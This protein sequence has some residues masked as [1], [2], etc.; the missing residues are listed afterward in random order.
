MQAKIVMLAL[1]VAS[2]GGNGG[3]DGDGDDDGEE[4]PASLLA[5]DG[6]GGAVASVEAPGALVGGAS[7]MTVTIT[8]PGDRAT[9]TLAVA[10]AGDGFALDATAT[11]CAG[12]MLAARASCVIGVAFEPSELGAHTGTSASAP[13]P[14]HAS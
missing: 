6:S 10:V 7:A 14:R 4:E 12:A 13:R 8:N 1:V 11:T 5:V 9:G 2:C 3:G